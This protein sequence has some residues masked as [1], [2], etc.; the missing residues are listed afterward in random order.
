MPASSQEIAGLSSE[1][2]ERTGLASREP[3]PLVPASWL[4]FAVLAL[5]LAMIA[6]LLW[7]PLRRI[8]GDCQINYN[9]GWN[10]YK[11]TMARN[12]Q[13]LYGA[14]PDALTGATTYPPVSFHLIGALA[15]LHHGDVVTT[16][17]WLSLVALAATGVFV[18]L[19]VRELGVDALVAAFAALL[20]I[21]G[22]AVFLPDR[23]GMNDPQLL[24]EAFTTAGLYL[25]VKW[26]SR[27]RERTRLLIAA[28]LL[29][30]LGGFTKQNLLAFPAAVGLDLLLRWRRRFAVWL[31]AM[32]GFAGVFMALTVAVDGRYF[33][34]HLLFQRTYN[35]DNALVSLTQFYLVSFQGIVL[36]AIVWMLLRVRSCP[37]LGVAF[38]LASGLAF[39]LSGGDGVDL[40]IY[41]NAFAAGVLICGVA[42]AE[43]DG[44]KLGA[45]G[46]PS[47]HGPVGFKG[48]ALMAALMMCGAIAVPDRI[49]TD[50]FRGKSLASDDAE[51]RKAVNL[52]KE[53]PGP[54]ICEN[55]LLCYRAGKPYVLDT[56][57]ASDQ[58][59]L[60]NLDDDAIP[61]M[62]RSRKFGAVELE[63]LP[64]EAASDSAPLV[65]RRPRFSE[66][67][68]D[69]L[70]Q[71]YTLQVRSS[72]MLVF[73]PK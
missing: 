49:E 54:A 16:G 26:Y 62:L 11:Q 24:G 10:A 29:F 13:P 37:L 22:I 44:E 59:D 4:K 56:F 65:R 31:A 70:L 68:T 48:A 34:A 66:E 1:T 58:L 71:N 19:I 39:W 18:G 2:G 73:V 8:G 35:F 7:L 9:E 14:R 63:V 38:V 43:F 67:S 30:C 57:V 15:R 36:V 69:A 25:Y 45:D 28:A 6:A 64:E 5:M 61:A 33:F 17:R 20:Y 41:F 53:T 27:G 55:L 23:L 3:R 32:V 21:L 72:H 47:R 46:E 60:G 50:H 42:V 51:F 12:G 40:N 52:L